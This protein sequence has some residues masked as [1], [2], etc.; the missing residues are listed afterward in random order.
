MIVKKVTRGCACKLRIG[1]QVIKLEKL[2]PKTK[3]P[4][5]KNYLYLS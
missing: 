5:S 3:N 2:T 1:K 4:I